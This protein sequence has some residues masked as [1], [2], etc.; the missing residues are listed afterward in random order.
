MK[1]YLGNLSY[2]VTEDDLRQALEPFGQVE[3][4][5]I[6]K[7]RDSGRPKGFGFAEMASKAEGQAAIEGLNGKELKGR[8]LNVNE[9][10]PR[11]ENSGGRGGYGGGRK[12]GY[13]GGRSG[14]GGRNG[15]NSG[16]GGYGGSGG[17]GGRGGQGRG[18]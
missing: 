9:A 15:Q 4:V 12:D 17:G 13:G 2:E 14:G 18:R 3:S 5:T 7:D 8:A 10:R 6:L 11:T 16:R 1:L